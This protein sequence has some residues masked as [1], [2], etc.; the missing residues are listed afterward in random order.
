MNTSSHNGSVA[1]GC[2]ALVMAACALLY[3]DTAR[4]G[5]ECTEYD[6]SILKVNR[7]RGDWVIVAGGHTLVR[8]ANEQDAA[9]F[10]DLAAQYKVQCTVLGSLDPGLLATNRVLFWRDPV[11]NKVVLKQNEDCVKYDAGRLRIKDL[12]T[13][14]YQISDGIRVLFTLK[15]HE[16]AKAALSAARE[17]EALCFI[18]RRQRGGP[19][20]QLMKYLRGPSAQVLQYLR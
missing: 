6:P 18:G 19:A 5:Q 8:L 9:L 7:E 11:G 13:Q 17:R 20:A 12:G 10:R 15:N 14:G 1:T 3:A 16:A 2:V 4:E